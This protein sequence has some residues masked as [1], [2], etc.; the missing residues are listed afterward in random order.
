M[1]SSSNKHS[2]NN[3]TSSNF[4]SLNNF[5]K[6]I[7]L[8]NVTKILIMPWIAIYLEIIHLRI[9][10]NKWIQIINLNNKAY[11]KMTSVTLDYNKN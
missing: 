9:K 10:T 2:K 5:I 8:V 4:N 7:F 1:L 3:L 6:K 11:K